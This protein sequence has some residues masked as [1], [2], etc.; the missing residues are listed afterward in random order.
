M[1]K[2]KVKELNKML[3]QIIIEK[4]LSVEAIDGIRALQEDAAL[5]KK[6]YEDAEKKIVE[7]D[8]TINASLETIDEHQSQIGKHLATL[9]ELK[10]LVKQYEGM[11]K[12]YELRELAIKYEQMRVQDFKQTFETVFRNPTFRKSYSESIGFMDHYK[13]TGQG[14]GYTDKVPV[15]KTVTEETKEE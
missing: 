10:A 11:A 2:D 4:T 7:M 15:G 1:D 6:M 8:K 3:K 14:Y 12:T 5:S 9:E 13:Q